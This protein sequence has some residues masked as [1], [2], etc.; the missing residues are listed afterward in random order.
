NNVL[1][2]TMTRIDGTDQNLNEYQGKVLLLV[3][4]ASRCGNTPQYSGL[5]SLYEKYHEKGFEVLAFPAND[6]KGQEP[7]TDEEIAEFC[8][9]NYGVTFP[10][11]SKISVKGDQI[12]PLY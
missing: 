3:N 12:D 11:F 6:F 7:G 1:D 9:A 2:R 10:M 8:T 5:Q 4:V